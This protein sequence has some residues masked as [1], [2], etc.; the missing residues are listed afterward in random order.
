MK[1]PAKKNLIATALTA[2]ILGLVTCP[3]PFIAIGALSQL[4]RDFCF[5]ALPPFLIGSGFLL[6]C[7]LARPAAN[8]GGIPLLVA[9]IL[10]WDAIA[11]FLF[12][13]SA[14]GLQDTAQR[15]GFASM[16]FLLTSLLCLPLVIWR[17]TALEAWIRGLPRAMSAAALAV[18]IATASIAIATYFLIPSHFILE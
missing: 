13:V 12:F 4:T 7:Y 15:I 16:C 18:V 2:C 14:I 8:S 17:E 6:W 10:S 11:I 9:E 5:I 1:L 3:L